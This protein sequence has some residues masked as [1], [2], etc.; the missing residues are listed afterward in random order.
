MS[1]VAW[2]KFLCGPLAAA[3]LRVVSQVAAGPFTSAAGGLAANPD[4][5]PRFRELQVVTVSANSPTHE[6]SRRRGAA[7]R[8]S[9]NAARR[10]P[11]HNRCWSTDFGTPSAGRP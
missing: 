8:G 3:D 6:P 11:D 10:F 1:A 7:Q 9:S 2:A 4:G 5:F